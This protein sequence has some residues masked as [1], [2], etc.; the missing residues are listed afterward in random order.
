MNGLNQVCAAVLESLRA[1]GLTAVA[2]YDGAAKRYGGPV[3]A[4]GV[5][6]VQGQPAGLGGYLGQRRDSKTGAAREVYGMQM[7]VTVS[8][9]VRA[10]DAAGCEDAMETAVGVMME[11]LPAGLRPGEMNWKG[12]SWDRANGMFLRTGTV[13]CRAA[14]T[15]EA[16]DEDG[17]LLDFILKGT[18]KSEYNEA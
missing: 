11:G 13:R 1:A 15:A 9:E 10:P 17:V 6:S 7:D 4:A 2:A 18:V 12:I 14:F 16:A 3:V 8:L 5:E